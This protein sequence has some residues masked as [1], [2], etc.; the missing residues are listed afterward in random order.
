MRRCLLCYIHAPRRDYASCEWARKG[1]DRY[2]ARLFEDARSGRDFGFAAVCTGAARACR[3]SE[4]QGRSVLA[5]AVTEQLD[6]RPGRRHGDRPQRHIWVFQR[7][8]SLTTTRRARRSIRRARNA[9]C[10]RRRCWCSIK[11]AMWSSRGAGPATIRAMTGRRRSTLSSSTTK[12]SS[13][14][15][16]TARATAWC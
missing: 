7:P 13:G 12:A 16:E 9:A 5:E 8:R 15:R 6:H 14:C 3:R 4:I 2:D 11:P 10:R 1:R